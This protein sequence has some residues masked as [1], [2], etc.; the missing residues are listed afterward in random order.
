M[1]WLWAALMV[2][3]I[4]VEAVTVQLLTIWF[5]VGSLAALIASLLGATTVW[6]CVIFV[7][8]SLLVLVLTRPYVKK[9]IEARTEPTNA[10]RCIGKEAIVCEKI[11]NRAG[12]GLVKIAGITWT[13]RS[14]DDSVIEADEIVKVEKIEGVKVIVSKIKTKTNV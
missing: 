1:V 14:E 11:D 12:Q 6:Q 2:V 10:D 13:A 3:F 9:V 4:I 7:V 8:V 5:A